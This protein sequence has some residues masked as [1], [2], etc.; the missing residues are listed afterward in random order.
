MGDGVQNLFWLVGLL[1]W[2]MKSKMDL[3]S[4][5]SIIKPDRFFKMSQVL[6]T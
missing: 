1:F 6:G 2:M 3:A 4:K 5:T